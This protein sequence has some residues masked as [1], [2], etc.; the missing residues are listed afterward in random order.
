MRREHAAPD[1]SDLAGRQRSRMAFLVGR[2]VAPLDRR[3]GAG[4]R[5]LRDD[6]ADREGRGRPGRHVRTGP[7]GLTPGGVETR[8]KTL[9][10]LVGGDAKVRAILASLYDRLFED[11]MVGFL[12]EGKDK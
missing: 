6:R 4:R 2:N 5:A 12:F 10:D 7:P 9:Y 3:Q 11:R 1:A 8:M